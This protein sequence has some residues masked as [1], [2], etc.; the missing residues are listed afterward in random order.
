MTLID[1]IELSDDNIIDLSSD[2]ETVHEDQIATQH[3]AMLLDKQGVFFLAG[4]GSQGVQAVFVAAGE[5]S[6]DEQA[7]FVA[8]N[9][10]SQD[11]QAVFV[12]ASEGRQEA[13]EPGHAL[14]ATASSMIMEEAPLVAASQGSQD[15]QVVSVAASEGRQ[16]TAESVHALEATAVS[17]VT[18][19]PPVDTVVLALPHAGSLN[20]L[21]SPTSGPFAS[22]TSTAPK[23]LMSEGGDTKL[24]RAKVKRPRKNHHTGTPKAVTSEG[25]DAKPVRLK[26]KHPK[27][28][29][30]TEKPPVDT[31]VL[32]LPHVGSP[33]CLGSPTSGP[34]ASLT[35]TPPKAL[36]SE[37]GDTKLVRA[38]V[39]RPR[40]NHH[41][42][43]PKAVTSE[44]GD[45]KLVRLKTKHP[46]K[47]NHTEKP[48]LGTAVLALPH[49]E[50]PNC[51]HTSAPFPS[52]TCT[53]PK[54]L[55]SEGGDANLMSGKVKHRTKNYRPCKLTP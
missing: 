35:S 15:V 24:V 53:S 13:S 33:N 28:K 16:E 30:H 12:A 29:N 54:A 55:S 51:P 8:A 10:G 38:K 17:L 50:S 1:F 9:E 18:E 40:K 48:P 22:L 6:Q 44:G 42:G 37:G 11:R 45:A 31:V 34:F 23:A 36:T 19:K 21:G 39:K 7:V 25:G 20:C 5:G 2:E 26:T 32:A 46:K 47:K 43:T 52:L 3:R 14:E 4:E 27:K 49:A 41:T